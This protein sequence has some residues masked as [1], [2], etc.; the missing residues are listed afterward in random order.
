MKNDA[1]VF[2]SKM[3]L[4]RLVRDCGRTISD[5]AEEI[6]GNGNG[7]ASL[8]ITVSINPS[9]EPEIVWEK[10]ISPTKYTDDA[11]PGML[12]PPMMGGEETTDGN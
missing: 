7:T 6:G 5:R 9:E 12:M 8:V 11:N 2:G 10:I 1:V 4:V 3:D